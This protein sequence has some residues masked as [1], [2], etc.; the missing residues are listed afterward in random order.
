[1]LDVAVAALDHVPV[2]VV[3]RVK[4]DGA[5]AART[6]PLAVSLLIVWLG[7]HSLDAP[8]SQV[9]ADRAGRVRLVSADRVRPGPRPPDIPPDAQLRHQRQKHR[10]VTGLTWCDQRDQRQ[11][12]AVDEL[13][14]LRREATTGATNAVVRRLEP[15]IR[16][17]RSSPL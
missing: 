16:V 14:D 11:P 3:G 9:G 7:N 1:M 5:T 13:M 2:L 8:L 17:I 6:T 4:R 10:R 12:V 15:R